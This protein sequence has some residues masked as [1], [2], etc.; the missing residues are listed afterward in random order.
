MLINGSSLNNCPVL[1]LHIGG[2]I[3]RVAEVVVDPNTLK[4]IGFRVT[5]KLIKDDTGDILPIESVREFSRMGM[6][7]DSIDELVNGNDVVRLQKI[8]KLNFDLIGMKVVTRKGNKLGKV[9][10]FTVEIGGWSI[11][12]LIIQRPALKAFFDP[13]L[14]IPR[15]QIIEVD[16][17]KVVVKDEHEKVKSKVQKT[18]PT[19]FVPNFINPFREPDFANEKEIVSKN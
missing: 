19:N 9:A 13:Q 5:G 8:L 15:K 16:D 17:Y 3:A 7:V 12:Q 18:E 1:S 10:D 11:Q 6:I 2:E 4:I 14:I